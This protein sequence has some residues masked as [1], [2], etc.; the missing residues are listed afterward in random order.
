MNRNNT[1][2]NTNRPT[3]DDPETQRQFEQFQQWQAANCGGQ[4]HNNNNRNN[5]NSNQLNRPPLERH[6]SPICLNPDDRDENHNDDQ[7][8]GQNN[9]HD[10]SQQNNWPPPNVNNNNRDNDNARRNRSEFQP[11][12][13]DLLNQTATILALNPA[14][15]GNIKAP[16]TS[17]RKV[18]DNIFVQILPD[19]RLSSKLVLISLS[20]NTVTNSN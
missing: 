4:S 17:S 11:G 3:Y 9:N 20:K 13:D 10:N 8:H 7:Y 6:P 2:N 12:F 16:D 15:T 5:I 19:F 18:R 1:N 14:M